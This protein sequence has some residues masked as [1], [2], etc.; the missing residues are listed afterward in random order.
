MNE[1][2]NSKFKPVSFISDNATL[3]SKSLGPPENTITR[4][5]AAFFLILGYFKLLHGFCCLIS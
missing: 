2:Y 3:V 1:M 4:E 5:R